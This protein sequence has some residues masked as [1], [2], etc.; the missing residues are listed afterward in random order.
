MTC[1]KNPPEFKSLNISKALMEKKIDK[2][3]LWDNFNRHWP[4]NTYNKK[5][6]I[7]KKSKGF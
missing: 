6:L 4:S 3:Q 2:I 7:K 5:H 1:V